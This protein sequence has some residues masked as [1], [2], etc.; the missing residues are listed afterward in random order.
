M[1]DLELAFSL[2]FLFLVP[3]WELF[4]RRSVKLVVF[5]PVFNLS[6]ISLKPIHFCR[7]AFCSLGPCAPEINPLVRGTCVRW[8][9]MIQLLSLSFA[10]DQL[11]P[12]L[13]VHP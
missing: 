1:R 13:L 3:A 12:G 11:H 8:L 10:V 5:P 7:S 9:G 6:S 2:D 4:C